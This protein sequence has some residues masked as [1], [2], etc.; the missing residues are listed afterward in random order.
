MKRNIDMLNGPLFKGI[1]SFAIP[2]IL[3]NLLQILF[4][5][6]DLIVVG[7]FC[8][9]L[10]V[11]A[12]SAT[13]SLT[14]LIV[15]FFIGFSVGTGLSVARSIGAQ[16]KDA[17]SRTVHTAIPTAAICGGIV[18]LIGVL[19]SPTFLKWM[20]TPESVLPLSSVYMRIYFSGMIF[21]M[22]YNFSASILRAA[23]ETKLPLF[24]LTASGVLNVILNLFFVIVLKMDVAGVALATTISQAVS[25]VLTLMALIRRTDDC[26]LI[27]SKMRIYS[28]ELATVIRLGLPA[29]LQ[30]SLFAIANVLIVSSINSFNSD[31]II[32]GNGAAHSLEGLLSSLTG[33]FST[34]A[35]NF[36]GQNSGAH[37]FDRVK[38]VYFTCLGC[39]TGV[40]FTTSLLIYL[41]REPL[42]SLYITDNPEALNYGIIRMCYISNFYFLLGLMDTTTGAIRGLGY[43]FVPMVI[44][45]M[46]A[47]G[48]RILWIYTIFQIP[49]CHTLACLYQ[50][51]PVSWIITFLVESI[52]FLIIVKRKENSKNLLQQRSIA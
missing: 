9:S 26:R 31:A 39:M 19:F 4:N 52:I 6:A 12:V 24:F 49:K 3:T 42:L 21:N 40:V 14:M 34:T 51:Y 17:V 16:Q 18:S 50:S 35:I 27:P 37:K 47:C 11:A 20:D 29:G 43:S 32:S 45:L 15:N 8:G 22:L 7:Q 48:L 36:I 46:G 10:S 5:T 2:V 38:K 33:A 30:S 1:L 23:G 25:A 44:T 41:L 13:N 28:K